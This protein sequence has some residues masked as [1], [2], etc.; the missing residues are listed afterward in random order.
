MNTETSRYRVPKR[1]GMCHP[2]RRVCPNARLR[3]LRAK[4]RRRS[5]RR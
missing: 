5:I 1:N 4:I 2:K 3:T